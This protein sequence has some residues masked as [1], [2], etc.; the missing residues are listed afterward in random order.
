MQEELDQLA[1]TNA[2]SFKL[3]YCQ[4]RRKMPARS[5]PQTHPE[6]GDPI[7]YSETTCSRDAYLRGRNQHVIAY[8][9][10]GDMSTKTERR[11]KYLDGIKHNLDRLPTVYPGYVMRIY[12]DVDSLG[13][14]LQSVCGLACSS[15]ALDIC[16]VKSLPGTPMKYGRKIIPMAWRFLPAL[17]PQ[18]R[19]KKVTNMVLHDES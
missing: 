4:C 6:T 1:R 7:K 16:H 8:S 19:I 5:P 12:T 2:T 13:E 11:A 14:L 9:L 17:D 10:F 18:V 15:T 3:Q